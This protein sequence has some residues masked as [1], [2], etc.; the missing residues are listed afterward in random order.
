MDGKPK[1]RY[2]RAA[3]G[4]CFRDL[5]TSKLPTDLTS[6]KAVRIG[7]SIY[8]AIRCQDRDTKKLNIGSTKNGDANIWNGDTIELLIET[9]V[10]AY[11]Q[12]VISPWGAVV[13]ADRKNE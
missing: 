3:P 8:F 11:Y 1:T 5:Q 2:G 6:F 10:H 12:I 9:Q 13:Q 7:D 4:A